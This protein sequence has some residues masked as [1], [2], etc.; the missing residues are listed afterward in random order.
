MEKWQISMKHIY[1]EGN[2]LVDYFTNLAVHFADTLISNSLQEF[3]GEGKNILLLDKN[4]IANI[5]IQKCQNSNYRFQ[6]TT[7]NIYNNIS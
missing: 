6:D 7:T 2:H 1:R 4:R 5:R 3:P